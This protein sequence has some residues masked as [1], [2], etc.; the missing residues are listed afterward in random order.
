MYFASSASY[1]G[2]GFAHPLPDG[3]Q[4]LFLAL[5]AC[6]RSHNL[7]VMIA[8]LLCNHSVVLAVLLFSKLLYSMFLSAYRAVGQVSLALSCH[9]RLLQVCTLRC[10][11]IHSNNTCLTTVDL[12]YMS[13]ATC[14][15]HICLLAHADLQLHTE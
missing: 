13:C 11:D 10:C 2:N 9:A 8:N 15:C 1:S 7:P 6:G 5:V 12:C 3:Q 14:P 4:Q